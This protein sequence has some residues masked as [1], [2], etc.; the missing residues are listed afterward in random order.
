[1]E[2][3]LLAEYIV[4]VGLE[5]FILAVFE[6]FTVFLGLKLELGLSSGE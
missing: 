6:I 1:L 5:A 3:L 2:G 4:P